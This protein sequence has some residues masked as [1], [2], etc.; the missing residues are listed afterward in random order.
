MQVADVRVSGRELWVLHTNGEP[1]PANAEPG[2]VQVLLVDGAWREATMMAR[3]IRGWGRPVS[4]P[5]T[6][7][8]RYWLRTQQEGARFSTVEALIF[9]FRELGLGEAS[10]QL[11]LQLELHVYAGLRARGSK[12]L[13]EEFLRSSPLPEAMPELLAALNVSRPR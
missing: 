12:E 1:L 3:E 5:M 4:L 8:S 6:G 13:A 9:L 11:Q 10:R 7:E 2:R